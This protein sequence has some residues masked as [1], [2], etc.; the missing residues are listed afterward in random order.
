MPYGKTRN[1]L[2]LTPEGKWN[3][4]GEFSR[5]G[6]AWVKNFEMTLSKK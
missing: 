4:V 6:T 2:R 5:D 1:T 3:E